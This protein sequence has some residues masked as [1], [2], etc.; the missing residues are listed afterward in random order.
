LS[1]LADVVVGEALGIVRS[2]IKEQYGEPEDWSF[3]V[4][5]IGKLGS[6]ELNFSSDIDLLYVYGKEE[7]ETAGTV[8]ARGSVKNRLGCHEYYCKLGEGLNRFLSVNT[9]EGFCYRVDLRLR[10]EGQKGS[11]AVSLAGYEIYYE[12]WGRAWERAV[13]LRARPIAGD[14]ALGR[15]FL[16]MVRPFVFRKYLDFSAI[17]EIRKMKTKIN[18]TF[19]KDDIKRGYGGI[20]EIEFF[21][22]ALELIYG[23]KEPLLRE[24]STLRG[25]HQLLLKN[26]IGREDYAVLSDMYPFLRKLEHRLQQLNDLQ[27]HTLPSGES[28]LGAMGRKMGYHDKESFLDD[29]GE[30][31]KKVRAIYDSLFM[32]RGAKV[33]EEEKKTSLLLSEDL[34]DSELADLLSGYSI[35]DEARIIRNIRHM[36]ESTFAFQTL[37]GQR[38]LGE[39]LP[40]FLDEALRAK[41]PDAAVNNLQS[42]MELLSSEE[43]YLDLFAKNGMLIPILIR[44]FSQSDYLAKNIM[45]RKEYLELL[46][47]EMF[48]RKTLASM[49]EELGEIIAAGQPVAEAIRIFKQMEEIRLGVQFLDRR[50]GALRLMKELSKTAEAIVSVCLRELAGEESLAVIGFGKSGGRELSFN[51]DLDLIFVC[52]REVTEADV[53]AAERLIRLLIS[54]TQDGTAYTVDTRLRPEGSKGPLVSSVEAFRDY[55]L[56]AAQF[57]EFQALLKARPLAGSTAAACR[58]ME[59]KRDVLR[60]KGGKVSIQD[61]RAMRAR[62]ER[63]LS[64]EAKGHDI[65]LGPGGLEELEFTV[66]YLQLIN[67]HD[68]DAL[69]VPGTLDGIAR[70]SVAG[71]IDKEIGGRMREIYVF[72]RALEGFLRLIQEPVLREHSVSASSAAE[73]TGFTDRD[74]LLKDLRERREE[75]RHWFENL[76]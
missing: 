3:A 54:Y 18:E 59:M 50:I 7:G 56:K 64:K 49:K 42:F 69:M 15:E 6:H 24:R 8:T 29:L 60:E 74:G 33:Q 72:Y 75:V 40:V 13:L 51:S 63:E 57:W 70:L 36:R 34:S 55:Y 66:Q 9:G 39:I 47:H 32:G 23:G 21:V 76:R 17:D 26:L 65:K 61:I 31:R 45:K 41:N 53:K 12:S 20:R 14:A 46:G 67:I 30:R 71:V 5:A 48:T 1:M 28:E 2:R 16:R 22:H 4:I 44:V 19:K 27:T 10:P 58:F 43:S 35:R 37:R 62:I 52:A 73:L 38:L 25:L 68:H 11:L